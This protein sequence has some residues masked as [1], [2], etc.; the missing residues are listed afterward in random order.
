MCYEHNVVCTL[1]L[2]ARKSDPTE[3]IIGE[4]TI[5]GQVHAAAGLNWGY[6]SGRPSIEHA[7]IPVRK[8]NILEYSQLFEKNNPI[9]IIWDD[10]TTMT[11]LSEQNGPSIG[12][13]IQ[14]GKALSTYGNK[15]I[16]GDYLRNRIGNEI[17][18]NLIFSE[19]TINTLAEI[20]KINSGNKDSIIEEI[21]NNNILLQE[22]NEKFITLNDLQQYG[23]TDISVSLLEN[24]IYYFDFS[25]NE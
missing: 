8:S 21:Q 11:L 16:L 25:V 10:G 6:S 20:K 19:Y 18:R 5:S 22:L 12:D 4:T 13:G 9:N 7:Y 14:Y 1:T 2:L 17:G 3:N 24:G 23:R 15:S